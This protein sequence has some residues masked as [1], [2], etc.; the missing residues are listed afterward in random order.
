MRIMAREKPIKFFVFA[1]TT[2]HF[3]TASFRYP[4]ACALRP[5]VL[6]E[7]ATNG[8]KTTDYIKVKGNPP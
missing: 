5:L 7:A 2:L 6:P 8:I 4:F 1:C 3:R